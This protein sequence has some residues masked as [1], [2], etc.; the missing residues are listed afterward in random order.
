MGRRVVRIAVSEACAMVENGDTD[1][2]RT[3]VALCDDGS[4]WALN[5]EVQNGWFRLPEIPEEEP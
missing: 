1:W 2:A 3:I 5:N 4:M